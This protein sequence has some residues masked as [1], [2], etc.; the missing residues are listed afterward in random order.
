MPRTA[1]DGEQPVRQPRAGLRAVPAS[2]TPTPH[3]AYRPAAADVRRRPRGPSRRGVRA[4]PAGAR[5]L[6]GPAGA[7][8]GRGAGG[9]GHRGGDR[10]AATTRS[11]RWRG[12]VVDDPEAS[13]IAAR[14]RRP[15]VGAGRPGHRPGR[16]RPPLP[17]RRRRRRRRSGARSLAR[18]LDG[19]RGRRG[20]P[21]RRSRRGPSPCST[22]SWRGPPRPTTT[23]CRARP[24][25]AGPGAAARRRR[26]R[27]ARPRSPRPTRRSAAMGQPWWSAALAAHGGGGRLVRDRRVERRRRSAGGRRSTDA[28]GQRGGRRDRASRCGRR[29]PSPST[30]GEHEVAADPAGAARPA[31]P[32]SPCCPSCSRRGR[33]GAGGGTAPPPIRPPT[34][35]TRSAVARRRCSA[36]ASR[37][38]GAVEIVDGARVGPTPASWSARAT[39][40]A[41]RSPDGRRGSAT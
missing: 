4:R 39:A 13:P 41:S 29:R 7:V 8:A 23:S 37:R 33:R 34:W 19:L 1:D 6:A 35:S 10:R 38:S 26:R 3:R 22:T 28:A 14:A 16:G 5:P 40:G 2:A 9:A 25:R 17:A 27:R 21:G 11:G 36:D 12:A 30:L 24:P 15:G 18:E 32:R 31:R 20:R